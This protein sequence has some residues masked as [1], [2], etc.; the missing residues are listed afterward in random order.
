MTNINISVKKE[1]YDFLKLFKTKEKSFSDVI[2]G[3]KKQEFDP[4]DFFG[5]L[6]DVDWE[7]REKEM[8]ALRKDFDKR[9]ERLE[10]DRT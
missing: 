4:M 2:L 1:A 9:I 10:S 3:F 6:K 7:K 8:R 5:V